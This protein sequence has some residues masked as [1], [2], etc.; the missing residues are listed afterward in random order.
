MVQ[1]LKT[2]FFFNLSVVRLCVPF[3]N[4]RNWFILLM[5][6]I[7]ILLIFFWLW[8]LFL[9]IWIIHN[10]NFMCYV[11]I[12]VC[13]Y[14]FYF[15]CCCLQSC[16]WTGDN[17]KWQVYTSFLQMWSENCWVIDLKPSLHGTLHSCK[18]ITANAICPK[19]GFTKSVKL[20]FH[21]VEWFT[22]LKN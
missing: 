12:A 2:N 21:F 16:P 15:F 1:D 11:L 13:K 4:E 14:W 22:S 9:W 20:N 18:I 17:G 3:K 10:G 19:T 6:F 5:D 8:L 7:Y